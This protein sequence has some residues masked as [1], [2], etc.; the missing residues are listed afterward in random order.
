MEGVVKLAP[1]PIKVPPVEASYQSIE[2]PAALVA[3]IVT[4][5]APHIEPSTGLIAGVGIELTVAVTAVLVADIQPVF[6]FLT[7]A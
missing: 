3:D 7:S 6:V 1:L 4:V 5:P 2:V